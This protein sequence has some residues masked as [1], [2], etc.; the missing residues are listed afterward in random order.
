VSAVKSKI[1]SK[2]KVA[3]FLKCWFLQNFSQKN[4]LRDKF[5]KEQ[6]YKKSYK[7]FVKDL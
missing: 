5:P 6:D 7:D 1:N 3:L 4:N 2:V